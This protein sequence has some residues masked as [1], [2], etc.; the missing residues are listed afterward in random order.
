MVRRTVSFIAVLLVLVFFSTQIVK[1][2]T[3]HD[4]AFIDYKLA[5]E[6]YSKLHDDYVLA[7]TNYLRFDTLTSRNNAKEATLAMLQSRDDALIA[8][9]N[10]IDTRTQEVDGVDQSTKDR[11]SGQL[12]DEAAWYAD[13]RDRLVAAG[14]IDDLVADS[15][16]ARKR[17]A[18]LGPV[19]YE[20]L[21]QI[22]YGRVLRFQERLN[23][24]F[25]ALKEK[26][27]RIR[28][29]ERPEYQF[30]T[31]KLESIDRWIFETEDRLERSNEKLSVAYESIEKIPSS[32]KSISSSQ[33]RNN[34]VLESL[35]EILQDQKD[36]SLRMRE[37]VREIKT[38]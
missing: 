21:S 26:V 23:E 20:P 24:N 5:L 34:Q 4:L 29:E 28:A 31:R 36:A 14:S 25:L 15:D 7:R 8:Y 10:A 27:N 11:L 32:A 16:E 30:T 6:S 13:H 35:K 19:I 22:P 1:A 2:E 33:S 9:F 37:I 18:T 12:K 3:E 17:Y 38:E